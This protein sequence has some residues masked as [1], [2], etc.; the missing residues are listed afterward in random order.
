MLRP[1]RKVEFAGLLVTILV[2]MAG[3]S[4]QTPTQG[5]PSSSINEE[6]FVGFAAV[7]VP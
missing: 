2:L 3:C 6:L 7:K 4:N 1:N 5:T